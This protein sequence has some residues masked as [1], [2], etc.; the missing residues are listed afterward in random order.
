VL[1][2]VKVIAHDASRKLKAAVC[3]GKNCFIGLN[4]IYYF[5]WSHYWR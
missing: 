4:A 1:C 5:A 3:I 2:G